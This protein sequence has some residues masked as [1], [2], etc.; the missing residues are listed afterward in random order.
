MIF[1][2]YSPVNYTL[3]YKDFEAIQK[4]CVSSKIFPLL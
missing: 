1:G 3:Y 4:E 2:R